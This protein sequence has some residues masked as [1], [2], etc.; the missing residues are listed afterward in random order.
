MF[1]DVERPFE[2]IFDIFG[3]QISDLDEVAEVII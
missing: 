1:H 3:I 2:C